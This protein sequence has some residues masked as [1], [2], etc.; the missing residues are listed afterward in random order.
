MRTYLHTATILEY[1][2]KEF[3]EIE[4]LPRQPNSSNLGLRRLQVLP[5]RRVGIDSGRDGDA[6]EELRQRLTALQHEV[7]EGLN[8][9]LPFLHLLHM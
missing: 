1:N 6:G 4:I 8:E 5:R 9:L 2:P 7:S 3:I